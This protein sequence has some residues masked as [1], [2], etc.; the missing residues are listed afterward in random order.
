MCPVQVFKPRNKHTLAEIKS[1]INPVAIR[2]RDERRREAVG[3]GYVPHV[4]LPSLFLA[5]QQ[6][7]AIDLKYGVV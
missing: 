7:W 2:A 5:H 3:K 1:A 6:K 4:V